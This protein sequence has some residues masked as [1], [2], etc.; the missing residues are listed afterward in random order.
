MSKDISKTA[1]KIIQGMTYGVRYRAS[2]L[3]YIA[4]GNKRA[5]GGFRKPQGSALAAGRF[6]R[7]L[8]DAKL[9]HYSVCE[10]LGTGWCAYSSLS[11]PE[12]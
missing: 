6:I 12:D 4:F 1:L 7:E 9:L 3:G 10:H 5:I 2:D 8:Y 11:K